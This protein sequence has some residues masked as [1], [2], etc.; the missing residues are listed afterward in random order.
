MTDIVSLLDHPTTSAALLMALRWSRSGAVAG[1]DPLAHALDV[2]GILRGRI[3]DVT[4]DVLAAAVL[5]DSGEFAPPAIDLEAALA[6]VS[7]EVARLVQ[8]LQAEHDALGADTIPTPPADLRVMQI[9]GAD[10]IVTLLD[11]LAEAGAAT[12]PA[13]YWTQHHVFVAVLRCFREFQQ[14]ADGVVPPSMLVDLDRLITV[15]ERRAQVI[16]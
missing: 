2:I 15:T 13:A 3:D 5:R 9:S 10:K 6:E 14:A 4:P 1:H 16:Q 7:L 11:V 12:D 8:A